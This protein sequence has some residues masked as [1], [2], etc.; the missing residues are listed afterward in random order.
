[1]ALGRAYISAKAQ[2]FPLIQL[3]LIQNQTHSRVIIIPQNCYGDGG[4]TQ[5]QIP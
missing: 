1:M 3:T 4:M 2:Q 5:P